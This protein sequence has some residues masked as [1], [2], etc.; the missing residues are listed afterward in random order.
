MGGERLE[1]PGAPGGWPGTTSAWP[2]TL[3]AMH[4]VVFSILM[5][6]N[7]ALLLQ[8]HNTSRKAHYGQLPD[9]PSAAM[10]VPDGEWARW[11]ATRTP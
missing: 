11:A 2:A 9:L 10:V 5:L 3:I 7:A 4:F 6:A 1:R 8:V